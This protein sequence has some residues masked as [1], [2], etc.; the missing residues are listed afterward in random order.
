M[1][2]MHQIKIIR[3]FWLAMLVGLPGGALSADSAEATPRLLGVVAL[4]NLKLALLE[5]APPVNEGRCLLLGEG[6][7]ETEV[8]VVKINPAQ[9]SVRVNHYA[10]AG[11]ISLTL[12][13]LALKPGL[14]ICLD[15]AKL[16]PVLR[17]YGRLRN[18]TLLRSSLLPQVSLT[19]NA[20]AAN[21]AEAAQVLQSALA[22]KGI[23][24]VPDGDRF[25]MLVPKVEAST[26]NPLAARIKPSTLSGSGGENFPPGMIQFNNTSPAQVLEV[27]G[28]LVG[29]KV[30]RAK[31]WPS[32]VAPSINLVTQTPVSKEEAIYAL[33][34]VLEWAGLKLV[35]VGEDGL[36]AVPAPENRR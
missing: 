31:P 26:V 1:R 6:Q 11:K 15:N 34:T 25:L 14:G 18:R 12:T 21:Y 2:V 16:D 19:L 20:V 7:R 30:Q 13:N 10:K 5:V 35:R 4:P 27:Y 24:S 22:E 9:P 36:K 28:S 17:L 32:V 8:Q 23:S 33:E 29:R 3:K